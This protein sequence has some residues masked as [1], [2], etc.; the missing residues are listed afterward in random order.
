MDKE[1]A[2]KCELCHGTKFYG[3]NGPGRRG[4]SE[5]VRCEI[6]NPDTPDAK[7]GRYDG[8]TPEAVFHNMLLSW[9]PEQCRN[10]YSMLS[11][12]PDFTDVNLI[13]IIKFLAGHIEDESSQH[14]EGT[15]PDHACEFDT[16]PDRGHCEFCA[17]WAEVDSVINNP[18]PAT[19]PQG[20]AREPEA[21][22]LLRRAYNLIVAGILTEEGGDPDAGIIWINDVDAFI[23]R[24]LAAPVIITDPPKGWNP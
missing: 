5:F 7:D 4:N 6:C 12:R 3:D 10:F 15:A 14:D 22:E 21:R 17:M 9:T 2:E 18:E 19:K 16:N 11:R 13:K 24:S 23:S 1:Q 8:F 20:E